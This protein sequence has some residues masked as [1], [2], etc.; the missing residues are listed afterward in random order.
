MI[1]V[2]N[3]AGKIDMGEILHFLLKN[4]LIFNYLKY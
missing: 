4:I 3:K 2:V 1:M